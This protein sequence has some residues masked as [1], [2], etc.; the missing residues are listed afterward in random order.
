MYNKVC[1][2]TGA[3]GLLCSAF[4]NEMAKNGA[5][6]DEILLHYYTGVSFSVA[7]DYF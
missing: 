4:A 1:V 7:E 5:S 2:I 3:G 6:Y